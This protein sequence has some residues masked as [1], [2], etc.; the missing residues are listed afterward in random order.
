VG[1]LGNPKHEIFAQH[2]AARM[3]PREAYTRAGFEPSRAN[4]NR[5]AKKPKVAARI[6][7]LIDDRERL[8][9]AARMQP[10]EIIR[11]LR[12]SANVEHVADFFEVNG[13]GLRVRDLRVVPV[14]CGTA[15]LRLVR[16]GFGLPANF[17]I[18]PALIG[19]GGAIMSGN[20][21]VPPGDPLERS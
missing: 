10:E 17:E 19:D 1:A 7:E 13:A 18:V 21:C 9:A 4:F 15:L 11:V 14:E 2:V 16:Q 8:V 5:L 12:D 3:P 6:R 20:E